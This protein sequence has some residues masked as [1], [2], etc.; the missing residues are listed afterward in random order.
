MARFVPRSLEKI[1]FP[2]RVK[3]VTQLLHHPFWNMLAEMKHHV[4]ADATFAED[5]SPHLFQ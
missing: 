4:A 3:R 2:K 5:A 1:P